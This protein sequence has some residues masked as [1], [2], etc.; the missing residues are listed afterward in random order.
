VKG[1]SLGEWTC[2]ACWD[3]MFLWS[4]GWILALNQSRSKRWVGWLAEA[5]DISSQDRLTTFHLLH[6]NPEEYY[7]SVIT[8]KR[9]KAKHF[10]ARLRC[11][12]K[13]GCTAVPVSYCTTHAPNDHTQPEL[14]NKLELAVVARPGLCYLRFV[15]V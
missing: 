3:G 14:Y 7:F 2:L 9:K 4:V 15:N 5:G 8:K 12:T 11:C 13:K 6:T 10:A 1:G